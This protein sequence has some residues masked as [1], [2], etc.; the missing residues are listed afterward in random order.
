LVFNVS[1]SAISWREQILLF[2]DT[3][4]TLRNINEGLSILNIFKIKPSSI[5]LRHRSS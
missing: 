4:K 5:C 1:I 2:T 3:Y